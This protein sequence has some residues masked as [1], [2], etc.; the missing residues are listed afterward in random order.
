ML[1]RFRSHSVPICCKYCLTPHSRCTG[2]L[3]TF[4]PVQ[5]ICLH[6]LQPLFQ[7]AGRRNPRP[8][9]KKSAARG[10]PLAAIGLNFNRIC[11]LPVTSFE[12]PFLFH[13]GHGHFRAAGAIRIP[14]RLNHAR[15]A[16]PL[17]RRALRSPLRNGRRLPVVLAATPLPVM[18]RAA[19]PLPAATLAVPA[20]AF[21]L[22]PAV[23]PLS[24]QL[25][26]L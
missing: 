22:L 8:R 4:V 23:S 12:N 26:P 15:R 9:A 14:T 7:E 10:S 3:H 21:A 5:S 25:L 17:R 13:A 1:S 18:S 6:P 2:P 16:R 11:S 24:L 20:P 19:R